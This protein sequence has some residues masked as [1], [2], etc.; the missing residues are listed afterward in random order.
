VLGFD[1]RDPDYRGHYY[2]DMVRYH[3]IG[4]TRKLV[5]AYSDV[6]RDQSLGKP[7]RVITQKIITPATGHQWGI[8]EADLYATRGI[9]ICLSRFNDERGTVVDDLS[10]LPPGKLAVPQVRECTDGDWNQ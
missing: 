8:R 10:F 5:T 1:P 3:L 6:V 2:D 9:V 7:S 4:A